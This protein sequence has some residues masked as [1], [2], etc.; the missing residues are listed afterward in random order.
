MV[1]S[2]SPPHRNGEKWNCASTPSLGSL[3]EGDRKVEGGL[4]LSF[5]H[6]QKKVLFVI[7]EPR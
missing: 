7:H 3:R 2:F 5:S 4:S 1:S 6:T